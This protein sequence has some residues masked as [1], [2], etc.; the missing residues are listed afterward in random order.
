[1]KVRL[2]VSDGGFVL[3]AEIP[4]FNAAPQALIWGIRVF[5]YHRFE[6]EVHTYRESNFTYMIPPHR[7]LDP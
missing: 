4:P 2:E 6:N 5:L 3:D 1:M 7:E